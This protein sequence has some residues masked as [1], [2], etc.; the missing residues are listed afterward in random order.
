M[1][2]KSADP[3]DSLKLD[4][5]LLKKINRSKHRHPGLTLTFWHLLPNVWTG[6]SQEWLWSNSI[7]HRNTEKHQF[8]LKWGSD[9]DKTGDLKLHRSLWKCGLTE[10][11]P[12]YHQ[13][14]GV[15]FKTDPSVCW[16][17]IY[18]TWRGF[19]NVMKM[20][21]EQKAA[22]LDD[23][24]TPVFMVMVS[25]ETQW[26]LGKL[27]L[28]GTYSTQVQILHPDHNT[29]STH[30]RFPHHTFAIN[31]VCSVSSSIL[32]QKN[33][34]MC[35]ESAAVAGTNCDYAHAQWT[36]FLCLNVFI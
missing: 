1:R 14:C 10:T 22:Y 2:G 32:T 15:I 12:E 7:S 3:V 35:K 8:G 27:L 23:Q 24:K 16:C 28:L 4:Q 20:N 17:N 9:S 11:C 30:D 25:S 6:L 5:L 33:T 26:R 34:N 36:Y 18:L 29:S 13:A 31:L 19:S 21:S